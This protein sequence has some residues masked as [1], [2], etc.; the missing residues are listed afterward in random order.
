MRLTFV[1]I[2]ERSLVDLILFL[3]ECYSP[4]LLIT[5]YREGIGREARCFGTFGT[6]V[7]SG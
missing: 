4:G 5:V 6:S 2:L 7:L 3:R 1:R